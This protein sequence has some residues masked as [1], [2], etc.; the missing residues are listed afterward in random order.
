[1]RSFKILTLLL[2]F[3]AGMVTL[4]QRASAQQ[5]SASYRLFY[6]ELSP[7]GSWVDYQNYGFVWMPNVDPDFSPY[8]TSGRWVFTDDGWT[9]VSDYPWGWATL[10]L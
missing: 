7:Y 2:A 3:I 5:G 4:T 8:V 10:G 9:W 1:M 6:D